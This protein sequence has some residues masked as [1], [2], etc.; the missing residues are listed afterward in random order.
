MKITL[1]LKLLLPALIIAVIQPVAAQNALKQANRHFDKYEFS[2]AVT[3]YKN[4]LSAGEPSLPVVQR[5]A[6]SYR[7]MNNNREAEFWYAQVVNFPDADPVNLLHYAHAAKYNGNF[8]KAKELYQNYGSRAAGKKELAAKLVASCDSAIAWQQNAR[9][10]TIKKA[11]GINAGSSDFSPIKFKD[12]IIFASDR[13]SGDTTSTRQSS[14]TRSGWTGNGYIQLYFAPATSDSTWGT[15]VA[16]P[17]PVNTGFHN[18]PATFL[19][20][21]NLLFFTRVAARKRVRRKGNAD[22]T[23]WFTSNAN[24]ETNRLEI[25]TAELKKGNW[26]NV[27]PFRYNR[28][29]AYSVGHPAVTPDGRILY[30]VSDMPGGAG[31]TDIYYCERQENG[32]WGKPV[33]AGEGINTPGR[34][35]F[36]TVG[37]DGVLYFSSDGHLGM[38]GLDI[39]KADGVHT[40]WHSAENLQYPINSSTDDFGMLLDSTGKAGLITSDRLQANTTDNLFAFDYISIPCKVQGVVAETVRDPRTRQTTQV[41]VENALV[42]LLNEETGT[43]EQVATDA[44]GHFY[45]NVNGGVQY[46]IRGSKGGYLTHAVTMMMECNAPTDTLNLEV[47]FNRDT[48]EQPILLKNIYYDLNKSEIRPDAARELDKLVRTLEENPSIR[49]ELS[50]HTDSRESAR[51]N[52][53]L[54]DA[55]ARAAVNYIVSRGIPS[56]RIVAKGYGETMILNRCVDGVKCSE[57]EHQENR[58]TEFKILAPHIRF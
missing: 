26:E 43:F 40:R 3:A 22:P 49:I 50:S 5:I 57:E 2:A 27:K 28:P 52:Q 6:D 48:P 16:L 8:D 51:Y 10:Y 7:L 25:Y 13:L 1:F 41:P 9:P 35:S 45:F 47:D 39:F 32:S 12:G 54:S 34:E 23:S 38:G 56:S 24:L 30:F 18:G 29:D 21:E 55:R 19:E 46:T 58:R 33:N 14:S 53:I 15:P 11:A 4:V 37:A 17:A 20:R 31:A 36:P 44:K 42:Q